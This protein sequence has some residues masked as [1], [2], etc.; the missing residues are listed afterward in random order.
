[1]NKTIT[2]NIGGMFFQID[3]EAYK[4]LENYL[5]SLKKHFANT[6]GKEE[7]LQDIE[8][9]IAEI[10]QSKIEQGQPLI[11]P[12]DVE[13]T[14]K[15][16]GQPDDIGSSA[17]E[18]EKQNEKSSTFKK[19][20]YRDDEHKVLGGVCSGLGHYFNVDPV[21][22]RIFFIVALFIF[23]SSVLIYILLWIIIPKASTTEE[24]L[25]MKGEPLT[26][27]E[28]QENIRNEFA[29]LRSRFKERKED[30]SHHARKEQAAMRRR[31]RRAEK[32]KYYSDRQRYMASVIS[33][34]R[35]AKETGTGF[36]SAL[37]EVIYYL[38]RALLIFLGIVLLVIAIVLTGSLILSLT[39]SDSFLFFTKW[40]IS[41]ISF[42]VLSNLFFESLWQQQLVVVSLILLIG[43]PLLMLIFNSIRLIAGF[44]TKIR[45][46]SVTA[47]L[48]WLTGLILA[49]FLT[50]NVI[51]N[52]NEKSNVKQEVVLPQPKQTLTIDVAENLPGIIHK[53]YIDEEFIEADNYDHQR[54]VFKNCYFSNY[55]DKLVAY[56]FPKLKIIPS[57]TGD[58]KLTVVRFSRGTTIMSARERAEA[59]LLDVKIPDSTLIINNYFMLPG[60]EKWRNQSV[61]L[62]LEVPE[63]KSIFMTRNVENL[64]YD[65]DNI[66]ASW[67][68]DMLGKKMYMV[69]GKLTDDVIVVHDT[70]NAVKPK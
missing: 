62:I 14:I 41:S 52:F 1:M 58:Y 43:V 13:E 24:K 44:K 34:A 55:N 8:S 9:R 64:I 51:G 27:S 23:G 54:F 17:E 16:L 4:L 3:E 61:K 31:M 25:N 18:K 37:G 38:L 65:K 26:I 57:K 36:G 2:I 69:G 67:N 5:D 12:A 7:I 32:E 30:A 35:P 21:W 53:P 59:I 48:L 50:V 33:Q 46:V 40:G 63:G 11:A 56:G 20:L 28:I 29:D 39:A 70:L 49:I 15:I 60:N 10:F 45:I 22:F 66:D 42:P 19:R 6:E 47:S 68:L